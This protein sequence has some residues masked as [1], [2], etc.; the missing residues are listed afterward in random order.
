MASSKK[1]MVAGNGGSAADAQHL[2]AEFMSR[3]TVDRPAMRA[4]AI[5]TD[6]SILT[7]AG[8]DYGFHSLFQRQIEALG[9][10][11]AVFVAISTSGRSSNI[12]KALQDCRNVGS[13]TIGLTRD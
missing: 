9:L 11:A 10:A 8:T 5:T 6:T 7:A 2:V 4:I 12:I 13:P 3:M 1:L